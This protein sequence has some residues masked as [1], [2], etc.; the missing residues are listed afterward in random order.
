MRET[1][2]EEIYQT[3]SNLAAVLVME[4]EG[5]DDQVELLILNPGQELRLRTWKLRVNEA[6]TTKNKNGSR[7][8]N[9][10]AQ[11]SNKLRPQIQTTS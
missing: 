10:A 6:P 9:P 8:S 7:T 5:V 2:L 1:Q 4:P 11:S 3:K